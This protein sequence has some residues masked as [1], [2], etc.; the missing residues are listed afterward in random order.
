MDKTAEVITTKK[1]D[2]LGEVAD[3]V[4]YDKTTKDSEIVKLSEEVEAYFDREVYPHVPDAHYWWEEN[5]LGAE[6]PLPAISTNTK[7][8]KRQKTYSNNSMT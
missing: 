7:P 3:G 4:V 1:K 2:K 5:K 6:I 8:Q